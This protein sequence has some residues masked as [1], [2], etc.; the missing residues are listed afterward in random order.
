M[1]NPCQRKDTRPIVVSRAVYGQG[2]G[3]V[4]HVM[5]ALGL[6]REAA[7]QYL[8][9]ACRAGLIKR[10]GW[11]RYIAPLDPSQNENGRKWLCYWQRQGTA[12]RR[13]VSA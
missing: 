8:S 11:G 13:Q 4:D 3:T 6:S 7:H 12:K 9:R 1:T 5:K 10:V 2:I